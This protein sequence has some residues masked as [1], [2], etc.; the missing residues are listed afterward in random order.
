MLR[1]PRFWILQN[2]LTVAFWLTALG[3]IA[4]GQTQRRL[5]LIAAI[6]L[7]AHVLELPL[8]FRLLR[9]RGLPPLKIVG[10][11]LVFG[12]TWWMPVHRRVYAG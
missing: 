1:N 4:T 9:G 10:M 12:Y 2:L 6:V 7:A 8:A 3:F 11:T 5:P